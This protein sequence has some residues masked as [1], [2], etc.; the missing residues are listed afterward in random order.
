MPGPP[1][2]PRPG[3][4]DA[5]VAFVAAQQARPDRRIS[6]VGTE[7]AGIAA[8]LDG[9]APPWATTVRVVRDGTGD[10]LAGVVVVECD[11][12]L[13]RAWI[14]G[15]WVDRDGDGWLVTAGA[16]VDAALAQLPPAVTQY[17]MSGEVAHGLLAELAARRGWPGGEPSHLLVVDAAVAATWPAGGLAL[18]PAAAGDVAGIRALHDAEFPDTYASVAE[19]VAGALDGTRVVLVAESDAGAGIAGYAAGE[20]HHDGEGFLGFVAV[21]PAARR[22]GVGRELVVATTRGLLERSSLGRVALTVHDHLAPARALYREL[23]FRPTETL[24]AY[25]SWTG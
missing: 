25:R 22:A 13:G 9:L 4:L 7:E 24:V 1:A 12:D 10:G 19:L 2:P 18:R 20:V 11:E 15:P 3:E 17:E 21:D 6:Y 8:E 16:L 14:V 5:V 23:G